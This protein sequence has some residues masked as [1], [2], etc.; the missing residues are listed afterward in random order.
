[1]VMTR[2]AS[3]R[4][5]LAAAERSSASRSSSSRSS[6]S[7]RSASRSS[8]PKKAKKRSRKGKKRSRKGSRRSK[9]R[10]SDSDWT[11]HT[12]VGKVTYG[13]KRI[14]KG[15]HHGSVSFG[16]KRA[17]V[18]LVRPKTGRGAG[19]FGFRV[20]GM[21][22]A[23]AKAKARALMKGVKLGERMAIHERKMHIADVKASKAARKGRSGRGK[24]RKPHSSARGGK[25]GRIVIT[26]G[27]KERMWR[28]VKGSSSGKRKRTITNKHGKKVKVRGRTAYFKRIYDR[29]LSSKEA[30]KMSMRR[31]RYRKRSSK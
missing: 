8:P 14:S 19:K 22:G 3:K 29:D 6:A 27:S 21:T 18:R 31:R 9:Y 15:Y 2:A 4:A 11:D 12:K 24:F 23:E 16:S 13:S 26:R 20:D 25:L 17:V 28:A 5:S 30:R 10:P 1:M 7:R